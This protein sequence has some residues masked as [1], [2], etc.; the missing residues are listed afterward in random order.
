MSSKIKN[1]FSYII[2]LC[3][4]RSVVDITVGFL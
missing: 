3:T 4:V 2:S 1:P